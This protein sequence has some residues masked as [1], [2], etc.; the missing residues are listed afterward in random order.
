[1]R[2][3][4]KAVWW[5]LSVIAVSAVTSF[6]IANLAR[7]PEPHTHTHSPDAATGSFHEWLHA[8]LKITP[9]QEKN[10]A[11][12]ETAFARQRTIQLERIRKAGQTL[13][14]ALEKAQEDREEINLALQQIHSAQG[15]LQKDTINH[16]LEMKEHLSPSQADLLLKW[17]RESITHDE[18]R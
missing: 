6:L 12:I 17:T 16:F 10:L 3:E 14:S 1:M 15:E 5:T 4:T 11:A 8:E 13:A 9:D 18:Q 7:E 2:L